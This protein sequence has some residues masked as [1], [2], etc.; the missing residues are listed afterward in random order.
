MIPGREAYRGSFNPFCAVITQGSVPWI[1]SCAPS[2]GFT[3]FTFLPSISTF[4][5]I[6]NCGMSRSSAR[7][8]P[9][10]PESS[11]IARCPQ[12]ITSCGIPLIA[13]ANTDAV[14]YASALLNAGSL[15]WI[16]LS[17]PI[18]SAVRIV[19][20]ARAGPTD[21]IVTS[22]PNFSFRRSASSTP[23]SSYGFITHLIPPSSIP[24]PSAFTL[25]CASVSGTC[26]THATIFT[27]ALL[28]IR[29]KG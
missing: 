12:N 21:T 17:A 4:V 11:S 23:N 28:P 16:P 19:S 9:T 7:I 29:S 22:P 20:I 26:F 25:I 15:M 27:I 1:T 5:M 6:V 8:A 24:D 13:A 14:P 2:T 18:A 3:A 10:C